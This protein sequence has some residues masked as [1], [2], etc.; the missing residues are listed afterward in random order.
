MSKSN[1]QEQ[2]AMNK[3]N[4]EEQCRRAMSN[5]EE[6]CRR[7][8]NNLSHVKECIKRRALGKCKK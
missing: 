3:N 7:A 5:E 4:V 1:E 6:Q 2:W 8:M